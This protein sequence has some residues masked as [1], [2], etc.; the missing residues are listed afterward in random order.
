[1]SIKIQKLDA[2]QYINLLEKVFVQS[3]NGAAPANYSKFG[4][5]SAAECE[6][7]CDG[8]ALFDGYAYHQKWGRCALY[9]DSAQL[10]DTGIPT[11]TDWETHPAS[12][13]NPNDVDWAFDVYDIT[14][15]SG[16]AGWFCWKLGEVCGDLSTTP[17]PEIPPTPP[18]TE[19][20]TLPPEED[21][22]TSV[23]F[24]P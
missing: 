12:N 17:E 3:G 22:C 5:E 9:I 4:V 20:P 2:V 14:R 6:S 8:E 13:A 11:K 7:F 10:H 16:D 21:D 23:P 15:N 18:V 1:M 24:E 19:A